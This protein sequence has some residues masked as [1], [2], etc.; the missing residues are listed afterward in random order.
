MLSSVPLSITVPDGVVQGESIRRPPC[1]FLHKLHRRLLTLGNAPGTGDVRGNTV[2]AD[3]LLRFILRHSA[4]ASI[5]LLTNPW[6]LDELELIVSGCV[7]CTHASRMTR[8]ISLDAISRQTHDFARGSVIF[9]PLCSSADISLA[10][11]IRHLYHRSVVGTS[12]LIHGLANHDHL[13]SFF[14][15]LILESPS[16]SD[17]FV[18]TSRACELAVHKH[19]DLVIERLSKFAGSTLR[20][21]GRTDRIP[22]PVDTDF[23]APRPREPIRKKLGWPRSAFVALYLGK[24]SPLKADLLPL[25]PVL[26]HLNRREG[27][28][29]ILFV[30]AGTSTQQYDGLVRRCAAQY[31][32]SRDLLIYRDVSDDFKK[33][34]FNAADVFISP[35]DTVDESFGL[36]PLE[37]MASGLPQV[38][39][40]WSG[41]RDTVVNGVTGF[42]VPTVWADCLGGITRFG[43]I[44]GWPIEHLMLGQSV[45][46]DLG[47]LVDALHTLIKEPELCMRMA[48]ASRRRALNTYSPAVIVNQYDDLWNDLRRTTQTTSPRPHVTRLSP[49]S[50]YSL[51]SHYASTAL[52]PADFIERGDLSHNA[53]R[54]QMVSYGGVF[55]NTQV[56]QR[57]LIDAIGAHFPDMLPPGHL[58]QRWSVGDI[59]DNI[60]ATHGAKP[61]VVVCHLL[62]MLKHGHL[63]RYPHDAESLGTRW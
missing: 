45:A 51:F 31:G 49:E 34:L 48:D 17:S 8:V 59:I 37:A 21:Q 3:S 23:F 55:R 52:S 1:T 47:S 20:F 22:L 27:A 35:A 7:E 43:P 14:L 58:G 46:V 32:V 42:L 25:I 16:T 40:N 2:A 62:W 4:A 36:A 5:D 30:F 60:G 53:I 6:F 13:H 15:R 10:Q 33:E 56:V 18:C 44:S 24:L 19:I 61:D 28:R 26:R 29:R 38:V 54:D 11:S 39:S 50:R 41:Y 12:M 63:K 57:S 9:S